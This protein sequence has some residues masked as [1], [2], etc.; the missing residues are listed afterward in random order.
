MSSPHHIPLITGTRGGDDPLTQLLYKEGGE[1]TP[2]DWSPL[3][4]QKKGSK[5]RASKVRERVVRNGISWSDFMFNPGQ[6]TVSGRHEH[7]GA[8]GINANSTLRDVNKA[9]TSWR[10]GISN[11]T[12]IWA[13]G[14]QQGER[15]H[16]IDALS[17]YP[18]TAGFYDWRE[19]GFAGWRNWSNGMHIFAR[20]GS[21]KYVPNGG[22][23]GYLLV[24]L[25][26]P[27]LNLRREDNPRKAYLSHLEMGEGAARGDHTAYSDE[28]P[29]SER[30]HWF[31]MPRFWTVMM[32]KGFQTG[33]SA[34]PIQLTWSR[35]HCDS[36]V[37]RSRAGKKAWEYATLTNS[38]VG[39]IRAPH[40]LISDLE[41]PVAE[42]AG[43]D[44]NQLPARLDG[45]PLVST[46]I[47]PNVA[48]KYDWRELG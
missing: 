5:G 7:F 23:G 29:M 35:A 40:A 25:V 32:I 14:A 3:L 13:H 46:K 48:R 47:D 19:R 36:I 8:C 43:I 21:A 20:R 42:C 9:A 2:I 31:T 17:Y 34:E 30:K 45:K 44:L 16:G 24:Q 39:S 18:D 10:T 4:A 28:V 38:G 22:R 37:W 27:D 11:R 1:L 12:F 15:S 33:E 6:P 41:T 26:G